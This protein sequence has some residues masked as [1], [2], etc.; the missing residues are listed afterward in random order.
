MQRRPLDTVL[1]L[2]SLG[3]LLP[4]PSMAGTKDNPFVLV[5]PERPMPRRSGKFERYARPVT[6]AARIGR[7]EPCPCKSGR[8]FKRC[9]MGG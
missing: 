4:S 9:C 7:N 1:L 3:A 6:P 5:S 2:A 8:K